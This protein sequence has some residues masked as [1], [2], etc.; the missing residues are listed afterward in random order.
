MS[1][2]PSAFCERSPSRGGQPVRLTIHTIHIES[3]GPYGAPRIHAASA[4]QGIQVGRK[5]VARLR[6]AAHVHGVSR[7]KPFFTTS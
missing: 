6:R 7:R 1:H 3:R 2:R 5:R 4:A